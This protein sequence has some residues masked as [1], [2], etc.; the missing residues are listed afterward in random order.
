MAT[1]GSP[2][3]PVPARVQ[4]AIAYIYPWLE[5]GGPVVSL[6]LVV[7]VSIAIW[8]MHGMMQDALTRHRALIDTVIERNKVLLDTLADRNRE[9][10]AALLSE[11]EKRV[12]MALKYH[13]C[14]EDDG[15]H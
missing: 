6:V 10:H 8:F 9:L 12:E 7:V 5:R 13:H 4:G 15:Q 11:R 14:A 3:A 1:N 2:G